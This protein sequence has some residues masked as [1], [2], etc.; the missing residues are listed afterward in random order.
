MERNGKGCGLQGK[1]GAAHELPASWRSTGHSWA[2][3][4][5]RPSPSPP[6]PA[7]PLSLPQVD[8]PEAQ[9][10]YLAGLQPPAP[11]GQPR[12]EL[13][14]DQAVRDCLWTAAYLKSIGTT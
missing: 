14:W 9:L 5:L 10:E 7:P 11:P 4:L 2:L 6:A 13:A 1:A 3:T 8:Q 12:D